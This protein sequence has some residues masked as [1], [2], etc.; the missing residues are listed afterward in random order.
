MLIAAFNSITID[1]FTL[2][3]LLKQFHNQCYFSVCFEILHRSE[4]VSSAVNETSFFFVGLH[5]MDLGIK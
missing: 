5:T 2:T 4:L 1:A 3:A